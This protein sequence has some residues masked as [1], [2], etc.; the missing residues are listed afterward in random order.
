MSNYKRKSET[1]K[2]KRVF[3]C[4][5]GAIT[6]PKYFKEFIEYF[7]IPEAHVKIITRD[8]TASSPNQILGKVN[9]YLKELKQS[10]N[11]FPT[12]EF[13]L[14]L[15][16]DR[17]GTNLYVTIDEAC[18]RGYKLSVSKPCFELW[19]LLHYKSS[20]EILQSEDSYKNKTLINI[21]LQPLSG[22][23]KRDFFPKT[24][25]AIANAKELD[26]DSSQRIPQRIGT[27][28]YILVQDI[29]EYSK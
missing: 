24:N 21:A 5:E 17:W 23:N 9:D 28:V 27:H 3:I 26:S 8:D 16:T 20:G 14:V 25:H 6:E 2:P 4:T 18:R 29:M 1:R 15:D 11:Y 10:K 22:I 13:W 7:R 19:L 12:D